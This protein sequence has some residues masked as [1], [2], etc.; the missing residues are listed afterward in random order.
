MINFDDVVIEE[1]KE[2]DTNWPDISDHLYKILIVGGSGSGK[3][4][5]V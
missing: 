1:T 3:N 2:H 4:F 5:I